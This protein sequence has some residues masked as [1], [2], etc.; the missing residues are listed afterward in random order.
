M[1]QELVLQWDSK[2]NV[3]CKCTFAALRV[4]ENLFCGKIQWLSAH[5]AADNK[6]VVHNIS[7]ASQ[8]AKKH[9]MAPH[10]YPE[11]MKS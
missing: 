8:Q 6:I 7:R 2:W 9:K 1:L 4:K 10:K 3:C 5:P 11:S